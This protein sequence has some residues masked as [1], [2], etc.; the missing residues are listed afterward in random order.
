MCDECVCLHVMCGACTCACV[1]MLR[2]MCVSCVF[3]VVS[4]YMCLFLCVCVCVHI[5]VLCV[6]ECACV[7][8]LGHSRREGAALGA[9]GRGSWEHTPSEDEEEERSPGCAVLPRAQR[10]PHAASGP[11]VTDAGRCLCLALFVSRAGHS[12]RAR[13]FSANTAQPAFLRLA[14]C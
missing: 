1:C 7:H 11:G 12:P 14:P 5:C 2:V 4:V 9:G 6:C 3:C 13:V 10:R 8:M